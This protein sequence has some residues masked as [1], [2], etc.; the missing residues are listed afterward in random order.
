MTTREILENFTREEGIALFNEKKSDEEVYDF[1]VSKGLTDDFETFAAEAQKVFAEKVSQMS[2]EEILAQIEGAEL[3]DEQLEMIA[4]G[5]KGENQA[6][7]TAL[8][9]TGAVVGAAVAPAVFFGG[10]VAAALSFV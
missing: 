4:G 6:S 2:K 1:L 3:T 10:T 7:D 9:V 5:D 8:I